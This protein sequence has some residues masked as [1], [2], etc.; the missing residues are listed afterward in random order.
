MAKVL[1]VYYSRTGYTRRVAGEIA[2]QCGADVEEI[3]DSVARS[4]ILGYLRCGREAM[5][6]QQ[7]VIAAATRNP[8]GYDLVVV[9]TPVWAGTL[10]SPV[11]SWLSAHS[12]EITRVAFFCT[13]GGSGQAKVLAELAALCKPPVATLA[14]TDSEIDRG[15]YAERLAQFVAALTAR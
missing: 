15:R 1:V 5:R 11:R 6:R 8:A 2:A 12:A 10:A 13:Q 9:G 4:G 3:R 14:L 7:P